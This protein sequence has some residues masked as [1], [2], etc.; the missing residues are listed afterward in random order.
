VTQALQ[1]FQTRAG[2]VGVFAVGVRGDD[3]LIGLRRIDEHF[4]PLE[5]LAAHHRH[6]RPHVRAGTAGAFDLGQFEHH[7]L[8]V[9]P[10]VG[11]VGVVQMMVHRPTGAARSGE[12]A[13]GKGGNGHESHGG[14]SCLVL[15]I[16]PW[17]EIFRRVCPKVA[18]FNKET[19]K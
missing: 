19:I 4:L 1:G 17:S 3:E 15:C 12:D 2:A 11:A 5:A 18:V 8:A 10:V 6:F 7:L 16:D 9:A 14:F 13:E